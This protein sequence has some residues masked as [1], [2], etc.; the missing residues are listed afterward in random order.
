MLTFYWKNVEEK[1]VEEK[2]YI[3][4]FKESTCERVGIILFIQ[5][6]YLEVKF[7]DRRLKS[8]RVSVSIM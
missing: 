1:T 7:V 2:G 8:G 4:R 5:Y 6:F 3:Y